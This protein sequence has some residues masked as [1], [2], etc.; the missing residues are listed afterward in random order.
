[1]KILLSDTF[2]KLLDEPA[3][4][5]VLCGGRGSGKSEFCA[6]KLFYRCIK[7][8]NHRFLVL[9]KVRKTCR[10]SVLEV[11]KR[12]LIENDIKY[13]HNKTDGIMSFG[14]NELLFDGLDEP[15]KIK[16][17]KGLTGVW[18]EEA[19]E[20]REDEFVEV[21][22]VLRE[23]GPNY[24][25]LMLSFN[26]DEARAP[27]L[28]RRFFDSID[29]R[30]HVH[31][32]TVEDNPIASIRAD[33]LAD[34]DLLTDETKKKIYRYGMWAVQKGQIY[35]WDVVPHPGM[36]YPFDE[37]FYGGDYGFSVNPASVTRIYRRADEFWVE[38]V[39]YQKGL[40]NLE[41]G[42]QMRAGGVN[43][44]DPIY[45]DSAE[46]K[47]NEEISRM[48]FNVIPAEKGPDS[49]VAG[50]DFV[51]SKKVHI[52]AG[53][54]NI[55]R[56]VGR[57]CWQ[58]DKDGNEIPKPVKFDDHSMDGIRYGIATHCKRAPEG[59]AIFSSEAVY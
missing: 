34:L 46:P 17:I 51:K 33:Y 47:S 5:L 4:Y 6:R 29:P 41:L 16:S 20:F 37:I 8:G 28:K 42:H 25:Q 2:Y 38:E 9:R 43:E 39:V 56:E 21:D 35:D 31:P 26:P 19:T 53:S 27:W 10:Q 36:D 59:I 18:I 3:R 13:A 32:S 15:E 24:L 22:L 45:F 14:S 54:E 40:I 1:M 11:M 49:V 52:I 23:P 50:V 48:G 55:I 44:V 58:L 12:L 30:A 57:Y 7:E